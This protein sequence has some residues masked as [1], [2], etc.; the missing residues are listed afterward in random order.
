MNAQAIIGLIVVALMVFIAFLASRILKQK[1][2]A[3]E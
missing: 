3:R 1:Q 2:G